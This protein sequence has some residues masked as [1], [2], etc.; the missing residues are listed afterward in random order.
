[1][2]VKNQTSNISVA[3]RCRPPNHKEFINK[4]LPILNFVDNHSIALISP[5]NTNDQSFTNEQHKTFSFDHVF[6]SK[7]KNTNQQP[8]DTSPIESNFTSPTLHSQPKDSS[9]PSISESKNNIDS[10]YTNPQNNIDSHYTSQ[11]HVYETVAKPLL[12]HAF[13]GYNICVFAYGQTSSGKTYTMIG[14]EPTLPNEDDSELGII[15]RL[16]K[17]VFQYIENSKQLGNNC[18][19]NNTRVE[20]SYLEIYNEKVFD[21]LDPEKKRKTLRIREHPSLGPYVEDLTK[22]AVSSFNE[23]HAVLQ[24]GNTQRVTASTRFNNESS[25]SH[26]VFTMK[27]VH[28]KYDEN[29]NIQVEI[30]SKISLVD[31]AGS[32]RTSQIG[33]DT[34]RFKEGVSINKSLTT[35]GKVTS[36]LASKELSNKQVF[37]P[38]RESSLTWLLKECLGG[39]SKTVL[40]ATVSPYEYLES[41]STLLYA[42]RAKKIVNRAHINEDSSQTLINQLRSEVSMLRN[43]LR[44]LIQ[45]E[46]NN[47]NQ[48]LNDIDNDFFKPKPKMDLKPESIGNTNGL[49]MSPTNLKGPSNFK[50][51]IETK[52][53]AGNPKIEKLQSK[54]IESEKLYE[55][56]IQPWELK[57]RRT[58]T[59]YQLGDVLDFQNNRTDNESSLKSKSSG[60][61]SISE[62]DSESK[63]NIFSLHSDQT[64][65]KSKESISNISLNGSSFTNKRDSFKTNINHNFCTATLMEIGPKFFVSN[66]SKPFSINKG[67]TFVYGSTKDFSNIS[68]ETFKNPEKTLFCEFYNDGYGSIRVFPRNVKVLINGRILKVPIDLPQKCILA[69]GP[70]A[71]FRYTYQNKNMKKKS[72]VAGNTR[73]SI[74]HYKPRTRPRHDS[75]MISS[76]NFEYEYKTRRKTSL[77]HLSNLEI[78]DDTIRYPDGIQSLDNIPTFNISQTSETIQD[79]P[80]EIQSKIQK[81][82][83]S[84][85]NQSLMSC[86][87]KTNKISL[88]Q[89]VKEIIWFNRNKKMILICKE[90]LELSVLIKEA[91]ISS[92]KLGIRVYYHLKLVPNE[93]IIQ[94]SLKE[95]NIIVGGIDLDENFNE[96]YSNFSESSKSGNL[97]RIVVRVL[98]FENNSVYFWPLS[99][100]KKRLERMRKIS[101]YNL[102]SNYLNHLDYKRIFLN[103]PNQKYSLIGTAKIPICKEILDGNNIEKSKFC[104]KLTSW[105]ENDKAQYIIGNLSI[106]KKSNSCSTIEITISKILNFNQM[107]LQFSTSPIFRNVVCKN[108]SECEYCLNCTCLPEHF[109]SNM[110]SSDLIQ[111][112]QNFLELQN[113]NIKLMQS[114]QFGVDKGAL[115][116][117]TSA[118]AFYEGIP[119]RFSSPIS[120]SISGFIHKNQKSLELENIQEKKNPKQY[121]KFKMESPKRNM[122]PVDKNR[123][124]DR[125]KNLSRIQYDYNPNTATDNDYISVQV[126]GKLSTNSIKKLMSENITKKMLAPNQSHF[127]GERLHENFWLVPKSHELAVH[128]NLLEINELGIWEKVPVTFSSLINYPHS[129]LRNSNGCVSFGKMSEQHETFNETSYLGKK[130]NEES[131]N[132]GQYKQR[133]F[134]I[135]QGLQRRVQVAIV[136]N[137][138]SSLEVGIASVKIGNPKPVYQNSEKKNNTNFGHSPNL[139][140]VPKKAGG[141]GMVSLEVFDKGKF[142]TQLDN[143]SCSYFNSV[144]DSSVHKSK[145]LNR[146]TTGQN[147]V[148]ME[149]VINVFVNGLE[150][151]IEFKIPIYVRVVGRT[152]NNLDTKYLIS[153]VKPTKN[154]DATLVNYAPSG[155]STGYKKKKPTRIL[156]ASKS[157]VSDISKNISSGQLD[158]YLS[159]VYKTYLI[160]MKP[161]CNDLFLI[162]N[163]WRFDYNNIYVRG[164]ELLKGS[165]PDGISLVDQYLS[166]LEKQKWCE[167]VAINRVLIGSI[168]MDSLQIL[169]KNYK[170]YFE[171]KKSNGFVDGLDSDQTSFEITNVEIVEMQRFGTF[172]RVGF[173][174]VPDESLLVWLPKWVCV[175]RPYI[176]IY[177][178]QSNMVL[179][180]FI[181]I[182]NARI[183][184]SESLITAVMNKFVFAVYSQTNT[185]LFQAHSQ[186]DLILWITAIDEFY[187]EL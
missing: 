156:Q 154:F 138:G 45:N 32:E 170:N 71:M 49:E 125:T 95:P 175:Q 36:A 185:F 103:Y 152:Q 72:K 146:I 113:P 111:H 149:I 33:N 161:N 1:M 153:T 74:A 174:R 56:F 177:S 34:K 64:D 42:E 147:Y 57:L 141:L 162:K 9:L 89:I 182:E 173:L 3:I 58:R 47:T 142:P 60:N 164:Q 115:P 80:L 144:W 7:N 13:D 133:V 143:R 78:H 61:Q 123:N 122:Q 92:M 118:I 73:I 181:Y 27:L 22:A 136:H 119:E 35:L 127:T 66:N 79:D 10:H 101:A 180:N 39:N 88:K 120:T 55:E 99:S 97:P 104:L 85:S 23:I 48:L 116:V 184:H 82:D 110:Y 178:D 17:D 105:L 150:T 163:L 84:N 11:K 5:Q 112:Q 18:T 12:Q 168:K 81:N 87:P 68:F 134:N 128:I 65:T 102:N 54:L 166:L 126:F 157:N 109:D 70:N 117:V 37:V 14:K 77:P 31:L 43:Q 83:L 114:K 16:C 20:V 6:W 93:N 160:V 131:V 44:I 8:S 62:C 186:T 167:Q 179:E 165:S 187:K 40:I 121:I 51:S 76:S 91:N 26:A 52:I 59:M 38:Y 86:K 130:N 100:F 124:F 108:R 41:S 140:G 24:A 25:R 158:C 132:M 29:K 159:V 69:I 139:S 21:L 107:H 96:P 171:I 155:L 135:R 75:H 46:K 169:D 145:L 28:N 137:S 148:C 151:G 176:F 2:N 50:P 67:K 19:T 98:D 15:P 172:G 90:L 53:V 129:D 183:E 4:Q 94:F 106:T 30:E 63:K